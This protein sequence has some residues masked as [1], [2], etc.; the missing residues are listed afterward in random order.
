MCLCVYDVC[1]MARSTV[2]IMSMTT[3]TKSSWWC[4]MSFYC[5]FWFFIFAANAA[6]KYYK[7]HNKPFAR[8]R[9][10]LNL[11]H[12]VMSRKFIGGKGE[13]GCMA[14]RHAFT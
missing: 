4:V 10:S 2:L 13:G 9:W 6:D 7:I 12:C 11:W 8:A 14:K 3:N 5:F 1:A